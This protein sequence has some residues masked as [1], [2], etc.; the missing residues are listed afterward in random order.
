M[1]KKRNRYRLLWCSIL[2][3]GTLVAAIAAYLFI[4]VR[5]APAEHI[6]WGTT[7]TKSYAEYLG[8]DWRKTY[9]AILDDLGMRAIRI[10]INWDE[11]EP[12]RG[13]FHFDDYDWMVAQAEKRSVEILPAVGFKLPRWP[14]CRAPEWAMQLPQKAFEEAQLDMMRVVVTHFKQS[15]A[16]KRWQME[17]EAFIEWFGDCPRM[18][19]ALARRKVELVREADPSRPVLMT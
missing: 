16:I 8:L 12:E 6:T 17:N 4:P 9:L 14:E 13:Q 2:A 7:F 10:G 19:D 18:G 1:R 3:V 11:V 5:V 15:T